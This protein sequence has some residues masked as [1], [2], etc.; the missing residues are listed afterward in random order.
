MQPHFGTAFASDLVKQLRARLAL[1]LESNAPQWLQDAEHAERSLQSQLLPAF[2]S[3]AQSLVAAQESAAAVGQSLS[4]QMD[5]VLSS[6]SGTAGEL[7]HLFSDGILLMSQPGWLQAEAHLQ[8]LQQHRVVAGTSSSV[9]PEPHFGTHAIQGLVDSL[10]QSSPL[11]TSAQQEA[12]QAAQMAV[13][14][15]EHQVASLV[16]Q[17]HAPFSAD[18]G[19]LTQ[20]GSGL[21]QL[22]GSLAQGPTGL[23]AGVASLRM[24]LESNMDGQGE[25]STLR[26]L[27]TS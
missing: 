23:G 10:V 2:A 11:N 13:W 7:H 18:S 5:R 9:P 16:S 25:T 27:S 24:Q 26:K 4:Q 8:S 22:G 12:V 21:R 6:L 3:P 20:L 1:P 14:S 17:V 15:V 19:I